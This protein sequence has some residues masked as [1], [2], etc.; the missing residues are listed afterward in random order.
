MKKLLLIFLP[1]ILFCAPSY[2]A[3][4]DL[5]VNECAN[6]IYYIND[7]FVLEKDAI[8]HK[9]RL[10]NAILQ[11]KYNGD[12]ELMNSVANVEL[13]Y[14]YSA[15]EKFGDTFVGRLFDAFEANSQL[16]S[17]YNESPWFFVSLGMDY[18]GGKTTKIG[19]AT[20]ST[21]DKLADTLKLKTFDILENQP[22]SWYKAKNSQDTFKSKKFS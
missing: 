4:K 12:K 20:D 5:N 1:I 18:F 10:Y 7:M 21:K 9:N 22:S 6:N 13:L 8:L 11:E 2:D 14:N 15:K 17:F 19:I 16:S 3:M